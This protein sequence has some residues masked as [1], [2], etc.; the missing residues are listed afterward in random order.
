V[1]EPLAGDLVVD[2]LGHQIGLERD[3]RGALAA[4]PAARPA[5]R[6]AGEP[7]R[8]AKGRELGEQLGLLYAEN[9]DVKPT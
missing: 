7:G 5:R 4:V 6:V 2:H 1:A 9:D 3:P 8:A